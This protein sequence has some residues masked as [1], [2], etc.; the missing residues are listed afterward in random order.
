MAELI[1][2]TYGQALFDLSLEENSVDAYA[3]ELQVIREAILENPDFMRIMNHPNIAREQKVDMIIQCLEGRASDSVTG[4]LV[5]V[6]KAG[7]QKY[8]LGMISYFLDAVKAYRHIGVV[9]VTSACELSDAQKA[10]VEK[11]LLETTD[12]AAVE[13]TYQVNPDLIGGMV[14][15]I[16]DKVA[17]NSIRTRIDTLTKTLLQKQ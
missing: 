15:R 2:K 16:G 9:H 6:V 1:D 10:A 17:D 12:Y 3:S 11:R 13:M 4:F 5:T 8:L 14:I 7:R